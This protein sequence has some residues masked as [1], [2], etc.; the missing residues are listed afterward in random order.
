MSVTYPG[1]WAPGR[2]G[3]KG[4]ELSLYATRLFIVVGAFCEISSSV[5]GMRFPCDSVVVDFGT[6]LTT[7]YVAALHIVAE[8]RVSLML[9]VAKVHPVRTSIRCDVS[10]RIMFEA[11]HLLNQSQTDG[12]RIKPNDPINYRSWKSMALVTRRQHEPPPLLA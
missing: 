11:E 1:I 8:T 9:A 2:P 10:A 7:R 5:A 12:T 3:G 6:C 4:S